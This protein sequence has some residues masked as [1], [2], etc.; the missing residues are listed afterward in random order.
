MFD[1]SVV[2]PT[3]NREK[4]INR[5]ID[6]VLAQTCPALEVIVVDD[7]STDGTAERLATY[8]KK[9]RI[10]RCE[11]N[12]ASAARNRGVA[13]ATGRWIAF[14]DSDDVWLPHKLQ[15]VEMALRDSESLP[16]VE[17][18][19]SQTA[20]IAAVQFLFSSFTRFNE[21]AYT[22]ELFPERVPT[23]QAV[24]LLKQPI[25][26]LQLVRRNAVGAPTM[27]VDRLLFVK[28]G[29]FDETLP[30]LEDWEFVLRIGTM[31]PFLFVSDPLVVAY[32]QASSVNTVKDA[33]TRAKHLIRQRHAALF[34]Q[35]GKRRYRLLPLR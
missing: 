8:G 7:G 18:L 14:H 33:G 5:A 1:C 22:V 11:N 28:S 21:S 10:I 32:A 34:K 31:T 4:T 3:Y 2:I 19:H 16:A 24:Q 12:G 13:E 20:E 25:V 6:S 15:A 17:S 30:A 29:G 26:E 27:V 35:Y 23:T 9:I